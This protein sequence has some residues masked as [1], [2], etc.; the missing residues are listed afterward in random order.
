LRWVLSELTLSNAPKRIPDRD[1][2]V[3]CNALGSS[4]ARA[5]VMAR[6]NTRREL[7]AARAPEPGTSKHA[8]LHTTVT[9]PQDAANR[10]RLAGEAESPA[11]EVIATLITGA[12]LAYFCFGVIAILFG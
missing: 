9:V 5:S 7:P 10:D 3:G 2:H 1:F 6:A 12:L 11:V 4:T 8:R